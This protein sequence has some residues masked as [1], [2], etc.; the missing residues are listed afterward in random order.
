MGIDILAVIACVAVNAIP[1]LSA[2]LV[3]GMDESEVRQVIEARGGERFGERDNTRE[4]QVLQTW[5]AQR[6]MY[7][8]LVERPSMHAVVRSLLD[9]QER[10]WTMELMEVGDGS[11][12]EAM[13]RQQLSELGKEPPSVL[14]VRCQVAASSLARL[15]VVDLGRQGPSQGQSQERSQERDEARMDHTRATAL[16]RTVG[17]DDQTTGSMVMQ[18]IQQLQQWL[19]HA[20][21]EC[22]SAR[23]AVRAALDLDVWPAIVDRLGK[24]LTQTADRRRR[25]EREPRYVLRAML[26]QSDKPLDTTSNNALQDTRPSTN[27]LQDTG[28]KLSV[29][30][31]FGTNSGHASELDTHG[32]CQPTRIQ[33]IRGTSI[34]S[35]WVCCSDDA[36]CGTLVV[37]D[38]DDEIICT[39]C[40]DSESLGYD[41]I[42]LC[43]GCESAVH[44]MCHKPVVTEAELVADQWF[45]SMCRP[46]TK[47]VRTK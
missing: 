23:D 40:G 8:Q 38:P 9:P 28:P 11:Q 39:V 13:M 20:P 24:Q 5:I 7:K 17:I 27:E 6:P 36:E 1:A 26:V 30:R 33:D 43:D 18:S 14:F 15:A 10:G 34:E 25:A 19:D 37:A 4:L 45:C 3:K 44:Q 2:S 46:S 41:Q 31:H 42:V 16:A 35:I 47:R 21:P 29:I 12:I 32:V 22:H